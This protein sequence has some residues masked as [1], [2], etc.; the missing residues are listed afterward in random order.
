[1]QTHIFA[2]DADG[3]VTEPGDLWENYIAPKYR[4]TCPKITF[5]P[6]GTATFRIDDRITVEDRVRPRRP[7]FATINNFGARTGE[8]SLDQTF[9]EGERGGFDPSAR[10]AWM[11]REGFDATILYPTTALG[12]SH[13]IVDVNRQE[14][15]ANAYN[16]WL[17]DFCKTSPTRLF[18]AALLPTLT[19]EAALSEI[20]H[21]KK[22]GLNAIVMKPNP[23]LDHPLHDPYFYPIWQRCQDVNLAVAIHGLATP[24]NLGMD[25]F[26]SQ[27]TSLADGAIKAKCQSFS[28]EHCFVHTAEMMAAATSLILGGVCDRFPKLRVAF[29]ESGA[30]WMPGYVDRMDR[31]FDDRGMNDT[32]LTTRPSEIFSR[33]CFIAFEPVEKSIALLAESFGAGKLMVASDYPHGDGFPN[34]VKTVQAMNLKP[35]VKANLLSAGFKQW[36]GVG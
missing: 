7:S 26:N 30:A 15:V 29:V 4:D 20:Q 9:L 19:T 31:H 1:M 35:D 23:V 18:G 21:A 27:S 22:L 33:Q 5:Q 32:G 25:R 3:H 36:Y 34:A 10:L 11:D 17:A 28:V 2:A 14:A 6:D 8:I 12:L 24:G 13:V 16:R